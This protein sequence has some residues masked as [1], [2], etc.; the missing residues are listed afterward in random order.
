MATTVRNLRIREDRAKYLFNLD[1][2]RYVS[3]QHTTYI[4]TCMFVYCV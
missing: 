4:L 3:M 1:P 2:N